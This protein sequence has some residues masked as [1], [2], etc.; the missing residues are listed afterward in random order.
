MLAVA[1]ILAV[2]TAAVGQTAATT[3]NTAG[4]Q[5][6]AA[7]PAADTSTKKPKKVKTRKE[8]KVVQSS[9]TKKALRKEKKT[10]PLVGKDANLPD[11]QLFDKAQAAI[12]AGHYDVARVELQTLLNTYSDSQYTMQAKLG[13]GDSWFKEGGTAALDQAESEYKDFI[14]F[15]PNRPEA[16]QAQLRVGDIY[17]R[18][19]DKP[20]RDYTKAEGAQENYR[21]MLQQF[22]DA[23]PEL[24]KQATQK[25]R[26]V[27]EV[28]AERDAEIGAFYSSHQSWSA[29]IARLQTV[30]DLYSQYSHMDQVLIGLGDIYLAEAR[31][32]RSSKQIPEGAREILVS[33]SNN[34]AAEY[35]RRAVL[36][37]ATS[38]H[39]EDAKDRLDEM[40]LT[41]PEPTPQQ[42]AASKALEDSRSSYSISDRLSLLF[43]HKPDTVQ[44]ATIGEPTLVDPPETMAPD[45]VSKAIADYRAALN[46]N[47][48]RTDAAPAPKPTEAAAEVP[49]PTTTTPVPAGDLKFENVPTAAANGGSSVTTVNADTS[50]TPARS[51][52]VGGLEIISPSNSAAPATPATAAPADPSYGLKPAPSPDATALPPVEKAAAAPDTV[53]E[54]KPGSQQPAPA[55][56]A[57][58][59][60]K[61]KAPPVDKSDESSSTKKKKKGLAK[62]N[63]F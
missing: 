10:D 13:I 30:V 43:M 57:P 11:K 25:L 34:K 5:T 3:D 14:T 12:K 28:L 42:I 22:P 56:T 44:A 58:N 38:P 61:P 46:P 23:P 48:P 21:L 49:A 2:S 1:G 60:K 53:N 47:A 40:G 50:S 54:I 29:A 41:P 52:S 6:P 7:A 15:F 37:H 31:I 26:D 55:T 45:V 16:A 39:V 63:P 27:Q 9:D 19:M 24:R 18:E 32:N 8:D 33:E 17:F 59:G 4:T 20:D 51:S 62:L 36:E 35:Y